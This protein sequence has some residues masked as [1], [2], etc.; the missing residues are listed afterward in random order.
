MNRA[1]FMYRQGGYQKRKIKQSSSTLTGY[2]P[3]TKDHLFKTFE[4]PLERDFLVTLDFDWDVAS[5]YDQPVQIPFVG[6]DGRD[7]TY[8]P[9][10]LVFY[11][12]D[13]TP[14]RWIKPL[15]VEIK[16]ERDLSKNG[17]S[18]TEKFEAAKAYADK[19]GWEFKVLTEKDI[20]T[21]FLKNANFLRPFR[22]RERCPFYEKLILDTLD[23]LDQT[24]P[25][26]LIAETIRFRRAD[27]DL[28]DIIHADESELTALLLPSLWQLV[29]TG[30]IAT[31]L[32]LRLTM[33]S[34]IWRPGGFD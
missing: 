3:A 23:I 34:D 19:R 21:P 1:V 7:H 29:D 14:A 20:R 11:R 27:P 26:A 24:T 15:L 13:R 30:Y 2:L 6:S 28:L 32:Q 4:S 16:T 10:V 31:D 5:F 33:T 17:H 8:T 9:D 25:Q 22:N 12:R 18:F